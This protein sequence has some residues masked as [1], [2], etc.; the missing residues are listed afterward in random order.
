MTD[1]IGT[2]LKIE[3]TSEFSYNLDT[4]LLANFTKNRK[5][6]KKVLEIGCSHGPLLLY[7]HNKLTFIKKII[8]IEI[9][10]SAFELCLSNLK[11]NNV[12]E[13]L[14]KLENLDIDL[15]RD[16]KDF[17]LIVCNPPF[18]DTNKTIKVNSNENIKIKRHDETLT[19]ETLFSCCERLIKFGG[20]INLIF[21]ADRFTELLHVAKNYKFEATLIRF[22]HTYK[23]K[24]AQSFLISLGYKRNANA[25]IM[26]P[27]FLYDD[28]NKISSELASIYEE[29]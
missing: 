10:K 27:L 11:L 24:E 9:N 19:L 13:N 15:Y 1:L 25:I 4:I 3:Q 2:D 28:K 5:D 22:I 7:L 29:N 16:E 18:F 14:V 12:D 6:Y 8:G 21:R 20:T 17:D 23:N 26:P